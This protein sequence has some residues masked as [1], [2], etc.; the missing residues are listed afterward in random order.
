MRQ[1]TFSA[2]CRS[3]KADACLSALDGGRLLIFDGPQPPGPDV[4]PSVQTLLAALPLGDPA[5]NPAVD[6][7]AVARPIAQTPGLASGAPA[8]FR[9]E[10]ADRRAWIDGTV[11][12]PGLPE[13]QRFDLELDGEI[14]QDGEVR[15]D[16][17]V[18]VEAAR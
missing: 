18:Y 5:F 2:A 7:I 11:G 17:L 1:P 9:L 16:R 13:A 15:I 4:E 6:G 3:V 12:P 10:T 14:E 8:W